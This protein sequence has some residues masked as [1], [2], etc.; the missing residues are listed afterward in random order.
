MGGRV[1]V[2]LLVPGGME[3][4]FA[5]ERD[6]AYRPPAGTK[7]VRPEDVASTVLFALSQPP[8]CEVRELVVCPPMEPSWP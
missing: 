6:E 8:G 2:T 4:A 1:G 5:E 7:L 3:T